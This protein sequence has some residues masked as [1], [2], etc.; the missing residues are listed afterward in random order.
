MSIAIA[1][2]PSNS[3]SRWRSRNA[4]LPLWT[5]KPSHTPSP[6]MKPLSNTDTTASARGFSSP[7]TLIRIDAFRASETSCID[8]A[9]SVNPQRGGALHGPDEQPPNL[10][11]AL[12]RLF[13]DP[14]NDALDFA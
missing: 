11:P 12:L 1:L 5:R 13:L 10:R 9:M 7:L 3:R 2:A 8:L 4:S 6:S 14:A